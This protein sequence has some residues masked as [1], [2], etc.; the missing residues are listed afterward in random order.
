[1]PLVL[2]CHHGKGLSTQPGQCLAAPNT[3]MGADLI[4]PV[5]ALSAAR[6]SASDPL[7]IARAIERPLRD[8]CVDGEG[9]LWIATWSSLRRYNPNLDLTLEVELSLD[10]QHSYATPSACDAHGLWLVLASGSSSTWTLKVA[11]YTK[12][13]LAEEHTL[14]CST[15][16]D[17]IRLGPSGPLLVFQDWSLDIDGV[18]SAPPDST[19]GWTAIYRLFPVSDLPRL[20]WIRGTFVVA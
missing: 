3:T 4:Y 13:G 14:T 2:A 10:P 19:A 11:R 20:V 16:A 17:S 5:P 8:G 6:G 1:L 12:D 9:A 7:P 18:T 15:I